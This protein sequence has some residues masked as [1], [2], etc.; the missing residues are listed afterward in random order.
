VLGTS[1]PEENDCRQ[2]TCHGP[3]P[4]SRRLGVGARGQGAE[5]PGMAIQVVTVL[6]GY[7]WVARCPRGK[8]NLAPLFLDAPIRV[9]CTALEFPCDLELGSIWECSAVRDHGH[10]AVGGRDEADVSEHHLETPRLMPIHPS[11]GCVAMAF[12]S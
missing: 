4:L 2:P 5:S 10:H 3:G 7:R 9:Q 8:P 12:V 6:R 1:M 11:F